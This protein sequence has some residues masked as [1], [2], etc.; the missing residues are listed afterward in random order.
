[1]TIKLPDFYVS[2]SNGNILKLTKNTLKHSSVV[3]WTVTNYISYFQCCC[4]LY[5]DWL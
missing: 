1:M 5:V 3:R 2:I 4:M